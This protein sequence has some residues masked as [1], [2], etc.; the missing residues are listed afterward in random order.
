[1]GLDLP[2]W[3]ILALFLLVFFPSFVAHPDG[4]S[5]PFLKSRNW[6]FD[7]RAAIRAVHSGSAGFVDGERR[8][9]GRA[10]TAGAHDHSRPL[11]AFW[12][13]IDHALNR[14]HH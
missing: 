7:A 1:M 5:G 12:W 6:P 8:C 14:T 4:G 2:N 9:A 3:P 11:D 10:L 13:G